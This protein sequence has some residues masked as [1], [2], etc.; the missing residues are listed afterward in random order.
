MKSKLSAWAI[1]IV[2]IA[3]FILAMFL[4]PQ[5]LSNWWVT[6]QLHATASPSKRIALLNMTISYSTNYWNQEYLQET[7]RANT[8]IERRFLADLIQQRFGTNGISA[9]QPVAAQPASDSAKSN[10]LAV[11]SI[12]E[13]GQH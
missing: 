2:F 3:L 9:L 12:L 5:S 8:E 4:K 6:H 7:A 13:H 11:V 10:V 1:F